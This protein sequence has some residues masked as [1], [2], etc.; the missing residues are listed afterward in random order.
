MLAQNREIFATIKSQDKKSLETF[1]WRND[2]PRKIDWVLFTSH[3]CNLR[4]LWLRDASFWKYPQYYLKH[5]QENCPLL[6][7]CCHHNDV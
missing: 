6:E 4:H 2:N 3:A 1:R 5:L 7:V